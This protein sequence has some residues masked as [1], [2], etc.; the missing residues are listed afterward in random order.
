MAHITGELRGQLTIMPICLDDYIGEDSV[1]RVIDAYVNSLDMT[2]MG[3]GFKYSEPKATGRPPF[4]PADM[5]KLYIYGYMNRVRSSRRLQAETLRNIEVMWLLSKLTPDDKTICNFRKDNA[6]AL[7]KAFREFS[8][9][10]VKQCLCNKELVAVDGTKIRANANRHSIHTAKGT[11]KMLAAVEAKIEKYMKL[12]DETDAEESEEID[13]NNLSPETVKSILKHLDKK[14]TNLTAQKTEIEANGGK[15]ISTVDPDARMM[16]TNGDGRNLDACYNVQGVADT[17]N[18]LVLDFDVTNCPDDK[19]A[20]PI[21]AEAAKSVLEVETINVSADKGNY[22]GEDIDKCE[23]NGIVSYVPKTA[24][25]SH[26]PDRNYDK[27]SFKYDAG[28]D[29]YVCPENVVLKPTKSRGGGR[30]DSTWKS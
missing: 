9:W 18:S 17:K 12:L 20:L 2:G 4:D 26:A 19:G 23:Q 29:T 22:D 30:R 14:K 27:S 24:D 6:D 25:Y 7:K 10:C 15:E 8:A 5:L 28:S 21:M 16:H 11:E 1:C 13:G 3:V